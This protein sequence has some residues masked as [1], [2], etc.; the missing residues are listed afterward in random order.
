MSEKGDQGDREFT[1]HLL[2]RGRARQKNTYKKHYYSSPHST[3][4]FITLTERGPSVH[5]QSC[6]LLPLPLLV[7][8]VVKGAFGAL[9]FL[10]F[11][12]RP[13]FLP[14]QR[15]LGVEK[16]WRRGIDRVTFREC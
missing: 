13:L 4:F 6:R 1:H 12:A 14:P 15:C 10:L 7:H 11:T 8:A 3:M 5:V 9:L 2:G 16:C